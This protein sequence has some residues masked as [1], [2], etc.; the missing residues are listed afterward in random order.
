MFFPM[1][2]FKEFQLI[3]FVGNQ[4]P[5]YPKNSAFYRNIDSPRN[6]APPLTTTIKAATVFLVIGH[7]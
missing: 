1:D 4:D 6:P 7:I 2:K 3:C 5:K